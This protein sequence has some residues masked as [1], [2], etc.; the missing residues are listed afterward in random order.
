MSVN[1][2]PPITHYI[3]AANRNATQSVKD[4]FA[5]DAI[6]RDEGKTLHGIEA[7]QQWMT[8]THARYHHTME[9]LSVR[10]E[11]EAIIVTNRLT[12]T[13]PGSPIEVPFRF[14]LSGSKIAKLEIG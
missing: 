13:F 2:P 14:V 11:G 7:I 8:D 12:G 10:T 6:V 1:M 9:P 5:M 4:Y 3:S